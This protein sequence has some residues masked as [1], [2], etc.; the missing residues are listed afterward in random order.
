MSNICV[1]SGRISSYGPKLRPLPS[2]KW[3]LSFTLCCDEPG[4]DGQIYTTF[5]PVVVYGAQCEPLAESLEPND[6]VLVTG[7]LSWTKKEKSALA[8][9]TFAVEV[10]AKAEVPVAAAELEPERQQEPSTPPRKVRRR[11]YPPAALSGGFAQ[12]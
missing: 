4:R 2:G 1:I 3:E 12:N 8:V 11:P 5:I 9:T 10:L 6:I 7:K